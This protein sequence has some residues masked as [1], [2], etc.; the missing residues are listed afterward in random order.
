MERYNLVRLVQSYATLR[1]DKKRDE[2][3]YDLAGG[4]QSEPVPQ[5]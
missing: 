2:T 3:G 5:Y 4:V 1:C